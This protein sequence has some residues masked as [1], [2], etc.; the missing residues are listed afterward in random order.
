MSPAPTTV[1]CTRTELLERVAS[2]SGER[3]TVLSEAL[4]CA[5]DEY[6]LD[7]DDFR[8]DAWVTLVYAFNVGIEVDRLSGVDTGHRELLQ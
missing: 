6:G 7:R 5:L 2:V 1:S 8:L 3:R 4:A